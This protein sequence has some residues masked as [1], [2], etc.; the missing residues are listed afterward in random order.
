MQKIVPFLW[1]DE[2][3]E[4]AALFYTALFENSQINDLTNFG[5]DLP[6]PRNKVIIVDFELAGL[7]INALNGGP[8]FTINPSISFMVMCQDETEVDALW[9]RLTEGG[10]ILM[11]LD[12]YPFSDKFGW[13]QDRYNVSWQI[14][15]TGA[16]QSVTPYL[17]F[18]GEQCGRAEEAVRFYTSL[19]PDSSIQNIQYFGPGMGEPEGNVLNAAFTLAGQPFLAMESSLDHQF[20]F[21]EA[22]SFVVNCKDQAEVDHYWYKLTD[23]GRESQCGWLVD[24]FGVSWQIVPTILMQLMTDPDPE[25]ASRVSKAM[26]DMQKLDIAQL[27]AAYDQA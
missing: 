7:Q 18:V 15:L 12:A 25:K 14:M 1:F 20:A 6:G 23:G 13:V 11:P 21:N 27:Q 19:F 26:L 10:Q 9:A 24:K 4:D 22:F 16:P 8:H 2:Q 17:L 3:A 5:D